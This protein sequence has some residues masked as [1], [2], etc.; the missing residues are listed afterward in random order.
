[1]MAHPREELL[2]PLLVLYSN[3]VEKSKAGGAGIWNV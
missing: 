2:L 1:M 3:M